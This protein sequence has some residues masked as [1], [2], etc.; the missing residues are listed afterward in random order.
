MTPA[1][2]RY[3]R[4]DDPRST[5]ELWADLERLRKHNAFADLPQTL[6]L[7]ARELLAGAVAGDVEE[8]DGKWW[9][10][11]RMLV[12]VKAERTLF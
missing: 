9:V 7:L 10:V 3:I 6:D 11:V 2:I 5:L 4:L 8:R 1:L 12:K